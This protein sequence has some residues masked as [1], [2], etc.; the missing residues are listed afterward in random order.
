MKG[1]TDIDMSAK[2]QTLYKKRNR[3]AA[4]RLK[5]DRNIIMLEQ[6]Q[7][8]EKLT[9]CI[10]ELASLSDLWPDT[11][12]QNESALKSKSQDVIDHIKSLATH[13]SDCVSVTRKSPGESYLLVTER[14]GFPFTTLEIKVGFFHQDDARIVAKDVGTLTCRLPSGEIPER[15][16][17]DWQPGE[18]S[19][20]E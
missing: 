11:S 14:L 1:E 3:A 18:N 16:S 15:M 10:E 5:A 6:H 7:T 9:R 8:L 12:S 17:P 20:G 2:L 13:D 19:P 4:Q